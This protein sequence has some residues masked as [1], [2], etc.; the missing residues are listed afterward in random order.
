MT[1]DELVAAARD[2]LRLATGPGGDPAVVREPAAVAEAAQLAAVAAAGDAEAQTLLG[3]L[4]WLRHQLLPDG[5]DQAELDTA[6]AAF[7]RA[8]VGSGLAAGMNAVGRAGAGHAEFA[9]QAW[10]AQAQR[11]LDAGRAAGDAGLIG[12]AVDLMRRS[13]AVTGDDHPDRAA[14]LS[15]LGGALRIAFAHTGATV[16]LDEAIT[17]HRRAV[18]AAGGGSDRATC[19]SNLTVAL[20]ARF[21]RAGAPEDLD[22]AVTVARQA[23]A[24][25]P[26]G[27]PDRPKMLSSLGSALWWRFWRT[28]AVSVL[29]EAVQVGWQAVAAAPPGHPDRARLLSNLTNRLQTRF[30]RTARPDDL[31]LAI[32]LGREAVE[33]AGDDHP[34]RDAFFANLGIA[35]AR[36]FE[37]AGARD[38]QDE[39]ITAFRRAAARPGRPGGAG[40]LSNLA[41]ALIARFERFGTLDDLHEA[42]EVGRRAV[43]STPA[44]HPDAAM[45]LNNL[46]I[47]LQTRF[48]RTGSASDLDEAIEVGRQ[49]ITALPADHPARPGCLANLAIALRERHERGGR[50]DDLDE[51]VEAGRAAVE[52]TPPDHPDRR[53]YL[54]GLGNLLKTQFEATGAAADL[55]EAIRTLRRAVEATPDGHPARAGFLL[56][57]GTALTKRFER[58]GDRASGPRAVAVLRTA[59]A[60]AASAPLVRA[61]AGQAAARLAADLGRLDE[62]EAAWDQVFEVLPL[63][64]DRGLDDRDRQHHLAVLAGVA[65]EAAAVA[66]E[67]GD[68]A[69]AWSVLEQGRGV[70]LGQ[71]LEGRGESDELR[72]VRPDLADEVDRL[73]HLLNTGGAAD[74]A[75]DQA[76]GPD[77]DPTARSLAAAAGWTRLL[78]RIREVPGFARF[79]LPPSADELRAAAAGGVVVAVNVSARRC[80]ALTLTGEG[81]GHVPLPDLTLETAARRADAFL[82]AVRGPAGFADQVVVAGT[83]RWLWDTVAAPVLAALGHERTPPDGLPWPRIWWLPTGPLTVLPLHA[84]G[85]HHE[86]TEEQRRRT[87]LDRVIS[88]YTPT[89]RALRQTLR[90][91]SP[92]RGP[93]PLVVGV[94]QAPGSGPRLE[95]AAAE[96]EQVRQQLG[97]D[98][99]LL[100]DEQA[101]HAAVVAGLRRTTWAHFACHALPAADP[102][103]SRLALHDRGLTVRELMSYELDGPYLAYLSACTTAHGGTAL[104]DEAIHIASAFQLAGFTHVVGTLWPISDAVAPEF[105]QRVYRRFGAGTE[106]ALAVHEAVR[107]MRDAYRNQPVHWASH[108]HF[109]PDEPAPGD[110]PHEGAR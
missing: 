17:T 44:D 41:N 108:V 106:P 65:T 92:G 67:R 29:D 26:D 11:L 90:T 18:A 32:S 98:T 76:G 62:A 43:R 14:R 45:Y 89:V 110:L 5:E 53:M 79:G 47:A 20:L 63:V 96:A 34:D 97:P 78:A 69:R 22:E 52:G 4:A 86:R 40:H 109:G 77:A 23:V 19:L 99:T 87:V 93:H 91:R 35:L 104:P 66:I 10:G 7:T 82:A 101:T 95:Q 57:L 94:D 84:A 46:G 54:N 73:R 37:S 9:A 100:L 75:G 71:A 38:D 81:A 58:L 61:R 15:A 59:A 31:D 21:E 48:E 83:L 25:A 105:A 33:A 30:E 8:H 103:D 51:A 55:D 85:V 36:R 28:D 74:P 12:Q 72:A 1:R 13:V 88:S 60:V 64:A 6:V 49:T 70:F 27:H 102:G 2:R 50:P 56:N 24:A 3:A 68:I 39:A 42:V 80:D 16:S 107:E